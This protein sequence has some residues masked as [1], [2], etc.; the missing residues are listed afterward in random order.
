MKKLL[1]L[2][3]FPLLTGC[4]PLHNA[5]D[6]ALKQEEGWNLSGYVIKRNNLEIKIGS[7]STELL[8]D[9][10]DSDMD[11]DDKRRAEKDIQDAGFVVGFRLIKTF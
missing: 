5:V 7:I 6:T 10:A 9:V 2:L 3:L 4:L 1:I 8:Y 11:K